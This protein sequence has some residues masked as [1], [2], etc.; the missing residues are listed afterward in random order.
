MKR[1]SVRTIVV[2]TFFLLLSAAATFIGPRTR[3]HAQ[4]ELQQQLQQQQQQQQQGQPSQVV[5]SVRSLR[6]SSEDANT[7]ITNFGQ[8]YHFLEARA[9]R[10]TTKYEDGTAVAE[11]GADG[12][13]R[14]RLRDLAGNEVTQLGV[15]GD[16]SGASRVELS[17]AGDRMFTQP[18]SEVRPTL[19]WANHQ[20]YALWKDRPGGAADVEWKGRFIRGHG[21]RTAVEDL[22]QETRAEFENGTTV[23][24]ARNTREIQINPNVRR[25]PTF[26]SH[27]E[28]NGAD[29]GTIRWY[30]NEKVLAWDYPGLT[31]GFVDT[32]RLKYA[33]GWTFTPTLEWASVQGL[34]FYEFHSRMKTKG[35][36]AQARPG[37]PQ[38]LLNAVSPSVAANEPGC[39]I[40]HWLDNTVFR[41][42]CDSHD[43][44]Y[45]RVG[46]CT[47]NS[48]YWVSW[49]GN[50]WSCSVCNTLVTVC[51][52]TGGNALI[53]YP[54]VPW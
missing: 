7:K 37:L 14:T 48:W 30:E 19:A 9:A 29:V 41:P 5:Q 24:S 6:V 17:A 44:C 31:K 11:R 53:D 32:D 10:V 43:R 12:S 23:T 26:I 20:A 1:T 54:D 36:V 18:R 45:E 16:P 21:S 15:D 47:W 50:Q 49:W 8:T 33:G 34:A 25:R 27:I 2:A 28:S 52:L 22:A 42:C 35:A 51:F 38:R 4:Q 46:G 40:L 3:A 13:F 39:D